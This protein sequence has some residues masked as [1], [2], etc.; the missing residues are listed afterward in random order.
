MLIFSAGNVV[1]AVPA[2]KETGNL[3]YI[4]KKEEKVK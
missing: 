1:D 2:T 4:I 3:S